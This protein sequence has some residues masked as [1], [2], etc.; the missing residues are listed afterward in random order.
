MN[1]PNTLTSF[2]RY[3]IV[4]LSATIV[5]FAILISLTEILHLWYLL[6]AFIGAF[7]GGITGFILGRNWAF[8]KKDEKLS[9]Q[10]IK[11]VFV[12]IASIFLNILGLYIM[13]E[14]VA[15]QYIISKIVIAI[16]IG[17]GFN[18]IMHKYYIFK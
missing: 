8:M 7:A 9:V 15:F 16:I 3:N 11:Y 17:I 1:Q 5:D 4:A 18:F 13:V 6:S 12:W 10:A 2:F 14:F